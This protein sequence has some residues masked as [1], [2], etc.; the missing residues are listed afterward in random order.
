VVAA[1]PCNT[2]AISGE[3]SRALTTAGLRDAAVGVRVVPSIAGHPQTG[4][5]RRFV[6]L[7]QGERGPAL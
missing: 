1:G 5:V 6:P 3:L 4:K 2:T 7:P